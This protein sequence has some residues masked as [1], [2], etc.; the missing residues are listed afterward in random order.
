MDLSLHFPRLTIAVFWIDVVKI[1]GSI[2]LLL[3]TRRSL[4][5][6]ELLEN[7]AL[8]VEDWDYRLS[9]AFTYE[10]LE[11]VLDLWLLCFEVV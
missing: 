3:P 10:S 2:R 9:V 5:G 6:L 7:L 4:P 1:L 8:V 11:F